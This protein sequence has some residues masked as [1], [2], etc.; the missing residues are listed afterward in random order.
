MQVV[1]DRNNSGLVWSHSG[2]WTKCDLVELYQ[3]L[4]LL[5][6]SVFRHWRYCTSLSF[7]VCCILNEL[8]GKCPKSANG[9]PIKLIETF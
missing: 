9:I 2:I 6:C 1:I 5:Y 3:G 4:D 8:L 7:I